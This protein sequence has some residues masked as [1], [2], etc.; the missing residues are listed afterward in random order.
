MSSQEQ[1]RLKQQYESIRE[2]LKQVY[3]EFVKTPSASNFQR[4]H[5]TMLDYQTAYTEFLGEC[6]AVKAQEEEKSS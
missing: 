4:L 3:V 6:E 1:V 2:E 5:E